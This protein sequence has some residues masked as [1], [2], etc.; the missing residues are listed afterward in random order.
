M[1]ELEQILSTGTGRRALDR[2]FAGLIRA[3]D[4]AALEAELSALLEEHP[5]AFAPLCRASVREGVEIVGWERVHADILAMDRKG[6]RCTALGIDLTGHWEGEGP[7]FEVSLYDDDSFAFS[8][9]SRETLLDACKGYPTP[10]QGCF[11]EIE[12]PLECRGLVLLDGAIRAYP[13]R[14]TVPSGALPRDYAGFVIA[15]WWLYLRV[16]QGVADALA[17]HGL[18]RAMPV[19][20]DEHDFGPQIGGVFMCERVADSAERSAQILAQRAVEKR[21]AYDRLT[22]QL[23]LE[24]RE[25]RAVV[26]NWSFWRNRAHRRN[27]IELLEASD[28]VMFQDVVSTR[29]QL[30]VW[31][32]SDREFEMLLDRYREH[33][34]PG[35]SGKPHPDPG[36]ERTQLHLLFLQHALQF[37]GRMVQREFPARRGRAA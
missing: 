30:S 21:L 28:K 35:S 6:S 26:R 9:A 24:M 10:W 27:A 16:H 37:G 23:I 17:R 2:Y 1:T 5:S 32:L 7:G 36:E 20:V 25:K 8:T 34:R 11:A 15:L 18:P 12:T 33:R 31:L 19:L 22:E 29:G 4:F 13:D 3:P 14:H